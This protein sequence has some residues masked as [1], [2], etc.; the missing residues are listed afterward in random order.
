MDVLK[1][2]G[3]KLLNHRIIV[4]DEVSFMVVVESL[5]HLPNLVVGESYRSQSGGL[6]RI[7][8]QAPFVQLNSFCEVPKERKRM[9]KKVVLTY[10]CFL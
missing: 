1:G 3:H 5:L 10:F 2:S 8:C 4:V 6:P 9:I 7:Y